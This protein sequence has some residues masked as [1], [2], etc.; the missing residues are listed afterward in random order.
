MAVDVVCIGQAVVDCIVRNQE[1]Q[2]C[3][4]NVYRAESITLSVGGDA[5]NESTVLSELGHDVSIVC[6]LGKDYAGQ[7]ILEAMKKHGV[8]TDYVLKSD[9]LST[10]IA[11]L[12]VGNDGGRRSINSKAVLLDGFIPDAKAVKGAKIVSLCSLFRAPFDQKDIVIDFVKKVKEEGCIICADTKLP[13]YREIHM[14]EISEVLPYIDYI[15]PNENEAAYYTGE[16]DFDQM[17]LAIQK[18]GV[19]NVIIKTGAKG[20]TVYGENE[21]FQIPARDVE[22]LDTTG[23]GDNFVAGFISGILQGMSLRECAELGTDCAAISVQYLGASKGI[24]EWKKKQKE[25]DL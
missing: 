18:M 7:L 25:G 11:N 8:H 10:P 12:I 1:E 15:F 19:K 17:A 14:K 13:S 16:E 21:H 20:C 3:R 4:K 23:A 6:G 24:M 9:S 5:V 2:E 22:A